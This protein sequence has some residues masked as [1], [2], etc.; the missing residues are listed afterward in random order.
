MKNIRIFI[1]VVLATVLLQACSPADGEFTGSEYMPDMAHSVA[2]EAN[3]YSYYY[4]NTWDEASTFKL[5]DLSAV[6]KPVAG[7]VPRGYAGVYF[8]ATATAQ[9]AML[10]NLHGES[11]NNAISVPINGDVPF[12]YGDS[13][14]ERTRAI[15]EIIDNPYP[16]TAKG[17]A[18]GKE[19]YGYYC[20]ICHGEKADG[21]GYLV[22]D[23]N[24]N[25]VYPAQPANLI[26]E[27][28]SAA[29]NGRFYY[30]IM[31]GK[32]VMGSY[33]D[34]L[35]YQE[36]WEV[37]HYIRSLQAKAAKLVY[38]G[39]S[40]TFNSTFGTPG[41]MVGGAIAEAPMTDEEPATGEAAGEE[42]SMEEGHGGEH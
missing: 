9:N 3:V 36:R 25:A 29:S 33:T 5:A 41:D 19:L 22:S 10:E 39:S 6:R 32:N 30:A 1:F 34:K 18:T 17:L 28:F 11:T 8:A 7:T 38:D 27:E 4:Y 26:N 24:T 40:N 20:G 37:I 2:Y 14:E 12:Y 35:S 21:A 31:Y 16:I 15:A 13:E 42:H 23:Q